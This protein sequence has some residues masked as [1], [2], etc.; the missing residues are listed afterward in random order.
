[1]WP[2][3]YISSLDEIPSLKWDGDD[4]DKYWSWQAVYNFVR[5]EP[6]LKKRQEAMRLA[7][8]WGEGESFE[9]LKEGDN[10][11]PAEGLDDDPLFY[12]H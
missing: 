3:T 6:D 9:P 10:W 5:T 12:D 1:M 11:D 4:L 2:K 8:N 7:Y